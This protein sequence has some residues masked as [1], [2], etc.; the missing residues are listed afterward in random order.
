M[1]SIK[2]HALW[3]YLIALTIVLWM[4]AGCA[5]SA[6]TNVLGYLL[7]R[8]LG[9][10]VIAAPAAP[11]ATLTGQVLYEGVPQPGIAV[12]V[13]ERT[14]VPYA[15]LTNAEGRYRIEGIPAGQYVPAAVGPGFSEVALSGAFGIPWLVTLEAGESEEAPPIHLARHIPTSLPSPLPDVVDLQIGASQIITAPFPAG[16]MA[17][18]QPFTFTRA[19]V[20]VDTLRL[21]RP[22]DQPE[23][24]PLLFAVF[25]GTVEGWEPVSVAFAFAGYTLVA[26]SPVGA[27]GLD[28]DAHTEDARV[29]LALARGGHLG[30]DLADVPAVAIGGS[31]SSAILHRLLRDEREDFEAWVTAGGI[32][33]AFSGA[34]DFYAGELVLPAEYEL[35]IP[36]L[37][38]A[39]LYPLGFL[40]YSPVYTAAQLPPTLIIHT[41]ADIIIPIEQAYELEAALR[42]AGVPVDVFYYEDV[43]HYLQVGE[44][45]TA[46]GQ[47]MYELILNFVRAYTE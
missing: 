7:E 45:L 38:A 32:S 4:L 18:M 14:G 36:A 9:G 2:S 29:A 13:A 44:D 1:R 35:V 39:N 34:A 17:T 5:P 25:P 41:D 27:H 40:R 33:N 28:I 15:T 11:P 46:A 12:V 24:Q 37:G 26:I 30:V 19:G 31:F 8:Q 6:E 47:E 16:A 23:A 22:V 10:P 42:T 20:I 43:S 3:T 21:Y